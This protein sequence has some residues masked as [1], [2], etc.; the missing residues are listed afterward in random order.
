[1]YATKHNGSFEIRIEDTDAARNSM[2]CAEQL[3]ADLRWFGITPS[4][5]TYQSHNI[6]RHQQVVE[7]LEKRGCAYKC[8]L[9]SEELEALRTSQKIVRSP[10]RDQ[11]T[12]QDKPYAIRFRMPEH[13]TYA[14]TDHVQGSISINTDALDDPIIL[15]SDR[16]PT[17]LLACMVDDHDAAITHILRGTEHLS[18][19]VRQLPIYHALGWAL[20]EHA[21]IPIV[22]DPHGAKLSKRTGAASAT[23]LRRAGYLPAAILNAV[24]RM[25]WAHGDEEIVDTPRALELFSLVGINKSAARFDPAKLDHLNGIYMRR[26]SSTA[27]LDALI[28]YET[29][30]EEVVGLKAW[31]NHEIKRAHALLPEVVKRASTIPDVIRGIGFCTANYQPSKYDSTCKF[32]HTEALVGLLR[33]VEFDETSLEVALRDFAAKRGLGF[34]KGVAQPLRMVLTGSSVSPSLFAVMAVLGREL[35]LRRVE[36]GLGAGS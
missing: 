29:T 16:S 35:V 1:L 6:T 14:L 26:M 2:E 3:L 5:V 31:N 8:Y 20:P 9:T 33:H 24:L 32:E 4:R 10:Y 18:N 30:E 34:G 17:Y 36:E 15:R 19:T 21:H 28:E 13:Q 12:P 22:Q 11:N 25:G 23:D 7:E 27:L